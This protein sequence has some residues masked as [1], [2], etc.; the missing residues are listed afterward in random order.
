MQGSPYIYCEKKGLSDCVYVT[1]ITGAKLWYENQNVIVFTLPNDNQTYAI[2]GPPGSFFSYTFT[3]FASVNIYSD[4]LVS[5]NKYES[6]VV[7]QSDVI[8][9]INRLISSLIT[10]TF[11]DSAESQFFSVAVLPY[12][13]IGNLIYARPEVGQSNN[14]Q[15]D[16]LTLFEIPY[17]VL[18]T[19][20]SSVTS[21]LV[22][23]FF[24]QYG[25]IIKGVLSSDVRFPPPANTLT[26]S[27]SYYQELYNFTIPTSSDYALF[28]AIQ[29]F[30]QSAFA[31]PVETKIN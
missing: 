31:F 19:K 3:E 28:Q 8:T 25:G 26:P 20:N 12:Q 6:L 16:N 15:S 2:F 10:L 5:P 13:L 24:G 22:D 9:G 23:M 17:Y 14:L 27:D 1:T 4:V 11:S 7:G 18:G 30:E 21:N 29:L